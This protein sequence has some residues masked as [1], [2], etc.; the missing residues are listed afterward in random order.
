MNAISEKPFH[1]FAPTPPMG[2]NSWDC[3]GAAVTEEQ[4]RQ[5]ADYMAEKL[6]NHG[7]EYIVVDIQ[8]YEP[9]AT[10]HKYRENAPLAMDAFGRL[11]PAV[12]RFPSAVDGN[13]FKPLAD[14][15]HGKGLKFGVHLLRGIPR[16][17]VE[18]NLPILGTPHRAADIADKV[19]ICPWNPDMFGV[20]MSKPGAQEY[21][22]SVFRLF[23]EWDVDFVKVDDL[24]R[25][26][27]QNKP[28]IEAIRAA[29]DRAGR[30]MVLS[31]SPGE[32]ALD[33]AEHVTQH[34][35]MWRTSDDFWDDW[36]L[37][38]DQFARCHNWSQFT[39]PGFYPDADM[40]PFGSIRT[41]DKGWTRFTKDEQITC[42]TLW[43]MCRSP[44]MFGGHMPLNDE[45][46]LSLLT[47]DEVLAV[48]Q[49]STGGRQIFRTETSVVWVA[50]VPHSGEKYVAL[51]NIGERAGEKVSVNLKQLGLDGPCVAR[52]LWQ[53]R[54]IGKIDR[55]ISATLPAHGAAMY[56]LTPI[57][58]RKEVGSI[59]PKPLFR[60]PTFD[61]AADPVVIYSRAQRKWLMFYTNRR[62][63][64]PEGSFKGV[65]W[66]HGTR[67]GVAKSTDGATWT[68]R[69]VA[70][71]PLGTKDDSH[72][73]PEIIEHA[74]V[75]HMFLTV[76]PGMHADWSGT[77]SIEHL[78]SADLRTWKHESTLKLA[79]DRVIDACVL[80]L[81]NG[82][83]RMWY[84]DET[85]NKGIFFADSDDLFTWT[86]RGRAIEGVV[87]EGPKV[88]F[89]RGC[90]WMIID[91]WRGQAVLR[92]DDAV[93]WE[94]QPGNLLGVAGKFLDDRDFGR[95]ADVV[96]GGDRAFCFY[97]THPGRF[98]PFANLHGYE[99]RRSSIQVVE[100]F[101]KDGRLHCDRDTPTRIALTAD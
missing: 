41:Y 24:S 30:P 89:W 23:A 70:D 67:I 53:Q 73:A 66:V 16:R 29:I 36:K 14:Y 9:N 85:A 80:R 17:A 72:W 59:A 40:L 50:D 12:N 84:N 43:A 63:N 26:Y 76:V 33:A 86:N 51:F 4:V 77:R 11:L 10:G 91:E 20:D 81:P 65:E 44:L 100:L 95:H 96:V 93:N 98:G 101:E 69:G 13:G 42:M 94:R 46:T 99:Q 83:W 5:N 3:F 48:N 62:A 54:D 60:D 25:P 64:L 35:N 1:R 32:T 15:I 79:S 19:H 68:Y 82:K 90:Y 52:D 92:S 45:F 58:Q 8:W 31:T 7:W 55:E 18:Q 37:L 38:L 87:G 39:G 49:S 28:E 78:T 47:N 61:G 75:Y 88:F 71:I 6:A 57:H 22:E 34:A 74:G 56:R 2:W 21:Y 97:F 27:H